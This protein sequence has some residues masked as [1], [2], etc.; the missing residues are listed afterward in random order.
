M[1]KQ[2]FAVFFDYG[3]IHVRINTFHPSLK[4]I[5]T[6]AFQ[7]FLK[8]LWYRAGQTA[9]NK[10]CGSESV[11]WCYYARHIIIII[12]NDNGNECA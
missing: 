2:F 3:A 12:F 11:E 1:Q 6:K 8:Q 5:I 7:L 9:E 4:E 10:G